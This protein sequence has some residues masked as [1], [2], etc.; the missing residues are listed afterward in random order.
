MKLT[1]NARIEKWIVKGEPRI[2]VFAG[3]KGI[4]AGEEITY[5][6]G[7]FGIIDIDYNFS[8]F[9]GAKEQ[10]CMCG[11]ENCRGSIGKKRAVPAPQKALSPK[12][13]TS[14]DKKTVTKIKRVENGRITK[15]LQKKV[16]AKSKDGKIT[17]TMIVTSRTKVK[18]TKAIGAKISSAS[19]KQKP[20]SAV[21][22]KSTILGKR[23]RVETPKKAAQAAR[24]PSKIPKVVER[25]IAKPKVKVTKAVVKTAMRSPSKTTVKGVANRI[26]YDTVSTRSRKRS[27]R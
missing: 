22:N 7:N 24:Q 15:V 2:G 21:Q 13:S 20:T 19:K 9:E 1:Q 26:I 8:W 23:K 6:N 16:K 3:R 14:K 10:K 17:A 25:K 18:K 27:V 11:A 4:E 5:G 12:K